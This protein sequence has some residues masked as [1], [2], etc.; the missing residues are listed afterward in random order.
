MAGQAIHQW[1]I[2][3]GH[4][5]LSSV[6]RTTGVFQL[7][8][9]IR[10]TE[11][12]KGIIIDGRLLPLDF[13]TQW[14]DEPPAVAIFDWNSSMLRWTRGNSIYNQALPKNS[15]DKISYLYQLYLTPIKSRNLSANITTGK[16]LEPYD[17]RNVGIEEIEIDERIYPAIHLKRAE[18]P[19]NRENIDIWLSTTL[20][21]LP[22]KMIYS[23][24]FG[25]HFEQLITSDTLTE[26]SKQVR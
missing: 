1:A 7:L 8:H 18:S 21:N 26:V 3:N 9:P 13:S 15:Y 19:A 4:Y 14:N 25:E 16:L 24:N 6:V 10:L 23:N 2:A 22:L 5:T 20:N 17:I 11:S 12:A